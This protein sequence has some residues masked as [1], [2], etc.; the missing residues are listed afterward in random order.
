MLSIAGI[1][2]DV[3]VLAYWITKAIHPT[4]FYYVLMHGLTPAEKQ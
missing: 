3:K 2:A 1:K 4:A